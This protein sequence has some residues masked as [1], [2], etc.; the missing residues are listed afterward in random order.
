[1]EL[2]K[3]LNAVAAMVTPGNRVC[4][5]GCDHGFIPIFLTEH[6]I[7]PAVIA[8]DIS[9]GPLSRAAEHIRRH[10]CEDYISV[11]LSDGLSALREGEADTVICAGMGG[12][13]IVKILT[14][15]ACLVKTLQSLILQPQSEIWLVRACIRE[16]G[17]CIRKEDMV[18]EDGKFY[19]V[20]LAAQG[21]PPQSGNTAVEDKF[22]PELL[23]SKN[24]VLKKFLDSECQRLTQVA[25][26]LEEE[27][28]RTE[29]TKAGKQQVEQQ[30][31]DIKLALSY[32]TQ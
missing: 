31:R 24:K 26:I 12:K 23:R 10:G 5:V 29:K 27:S 3:R 28:P 11:R 19:P 17:F 14:D 15:C 7:S 22:G 4:D 16:L 30:L 6:G 2:S 13:L 8:M 1:M 18:L 32:Y 25:Y 9:R 20:I 21:E